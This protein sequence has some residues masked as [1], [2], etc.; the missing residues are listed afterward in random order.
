MSDEWEGKKY[1]LLPNMA[2]K[3]ELEKIKLREKIATKDAEL[4]RLREALEF[5]A[6]E[7]NWAMHPE[8]AN[9]CCLDSADYGQKAREAL[10]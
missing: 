5:Y 6:N 8:Y 1:G 4:A 7:S 3:H 10:K 9:A 2:G